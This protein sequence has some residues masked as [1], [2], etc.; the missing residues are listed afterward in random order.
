MRSTT[1]RSISRGTRPPPPIHFSISSMP[2]PSRSARAFLPPMS[3]AAFRTARLS[4]LVAM[5]IPWRH[6]GFMIMQATRRHNVARRLEFRTLLS[7]PRRPGVGVEQ[8]DLQCRKKYLLRR[9]FLSFQPHVQG[10]FRHTG[11]HR[12]MCRPAEDPASPVERSRVRAPRS[13][14]WFAF[15]WHSPHIAHLPCS[16]R[17]PP[18]SAVE[19]SGPAGVV[20]WRQAGNQSPGATG[21]ALATM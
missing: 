4:I 14:R 13:V 11:M 9:F 2:T 19:W 8:Y 3:S 12:E 15:A 16:C 1:R 10:R 20:Q 7:L 18:K 5:S 6:V 17:R 21:T